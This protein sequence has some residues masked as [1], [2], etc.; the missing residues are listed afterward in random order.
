M[1]LAGEKLH[2]S[3]R[4]IHTQSCCWFLVLPQNNFK[5]VSQFIFFRRLKRLNPYIKTFSSFKKLYLFGLLSVNRL[6]KKK[7]DPLS[8]F[9]MKILPKI[10]RK[11]FGKERYLIFS[12][13]TNL[14][15]EPRLNA[16]ATKT[17]KKNV[18]AKNQKKDPNNHEK[19]NWGGLN[20]MKKIH[21][22]LC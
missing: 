16:N 15:K 12:T 9:C 8:S 14:K 5:L 21:K 22:K 2:S 20:L 11:R 3:H 4:P 13:N 1:F 18:L 10:T 7:W 19:P 6:H 17:Y